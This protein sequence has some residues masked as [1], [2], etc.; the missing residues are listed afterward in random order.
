[1]AHQSDLSEEEGQTKVTLNHSS[2]EK[3]DAKM[4]NDMEQGWNES[5]DK[6]NEYLKQKFGMV[7]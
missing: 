7:G 3:I 4:L 2:N 6:L 1:M 5:F